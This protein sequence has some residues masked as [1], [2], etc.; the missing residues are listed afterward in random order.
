[1]VADLFFPGAG[2]VTAVGVRLY[3]N[4]LLQNLDLRKLASISV[5]KTQT[6]IEFL[7]THIRLAHWRLSF[8]PKVRPRERQQD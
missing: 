5:C 6:T 1:V 2:F 4:R 8:Y 3:G 7:Q